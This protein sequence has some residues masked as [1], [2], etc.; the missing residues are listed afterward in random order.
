MQE[1]IDF[2]VLECGY[3]EIRRAMFAGG[4]PAARGGGKGRT[5]GKVRALRLCHLEMQK[6]MVLRQDVV[7]GKDVLVLEM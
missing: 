4:P 3:P 2:K 7:D 1:P 6:R 5:R